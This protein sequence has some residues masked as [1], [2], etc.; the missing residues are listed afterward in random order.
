MR[1]TKYDVLCLNWVVTSVAR[2]ANKFYT[3]Y[4]LYTIYLHN[5]LN[6]KMFSLAELVYTFP[7]FCIQ[8]HLYYWQLSSAERLKLKRQELIIFYLFP[9]HNM[10]VHKQTLI[11]TFS[12]FSLQNS[13]QMK[14]CEMKTISIFY[15]ICVSSQVH[16]DSN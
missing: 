15:T 1:Q 2:V 6:F 5:I 16:K 4:I 13:H 7:N 12:L 3:F 14:F 11:E 8:F 10:W 9:H